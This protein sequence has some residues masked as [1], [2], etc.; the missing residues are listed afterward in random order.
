MTTIHLT[1]GDLIGLRFAYRPLLEIGTSYA[2]LNHYFFQAPY[3]R[4]VEEAYRALHDVELPY[5]AALVPPNSTYTPDFLTPTPTAKQHSIEDD[6]RDLLATPDA[7]V[8]KNVQKLIDAMG[9]SETRQHF[10][11]YPREALQ[12]L[13]EDLR[14]Y[15]QRTLAHHWSHMISAL[16]SDILYRG[17][18]LALEGPG[19]LLSGLHSTIFYQNHQ[20]QLEPAPNSSIH[21]D[22]HFKLS[23]DGLQIVPLFFTGT[24]RGWQISPE[25]RPMLGYRIRGIGA[26]SQ[27][28]PS[29]IQSLAL[30]LGTSRA[31][32]LQAL[33]TPATNTEIAH[34]LQNSAGA[35]SQH[36]HRLTKAG[37]VRP[38]RVGKRVYYQLTQRGE[39]LLTLF[40]RT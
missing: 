6:F 10:L 38:H 11:T 1:T 12:C 40:D 21:P 35:I 18:L 27:V 3:T 37:L 26:Q 9:H 16:E 32:V 4:W 30:A 25:W 22:V 2:I 14:H 31:E 34:K 5:L 17:R 19:Q 28:S 20:I 29:T 39:N 33:V 23:G 7:L 8:R 13:V 36:L 24:G 15:W